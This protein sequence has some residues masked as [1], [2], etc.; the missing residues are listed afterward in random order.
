MATNPAPQDCS[1]TRALLVILAFGLA[2]SLI[3]NVTLVVAAKQLYAQRCAV[4][5]D[6]VGLAKFASEAPGEHAPSLV[7]FGDSRAAQWRTPA[8]IAGHRVINRGISG[9]TSAQVRARLEEHVLHLKPRVVV[10]EVGMNDLKTLPLFKSE[11]GKIV[12]RCIANIEYVAR[13]I[14]QSGPTVVLVTVFPVGKVP[15]Y[16]KPIY[17][18]DVDEAIRRVNE[19]IRNLDGERIRVLDADSFLMNA[20]GRLRPEYGRDM[21]HLNAAGYEQLNQRLI[22]LLEMI[23]N[24]PA[25]EDLLRG[26]DH[27]GGIAGDD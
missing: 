27:A 16:R 21:L 22:P 4:E 12:D 15:W 11:T 3:A 7:L 26:S 23:L 10:L 6:P 1:R 2:V 18:R 5:L 24:Q 25:A 20:A 14:A 17:S 19:R 9:Q 8:T 13:T